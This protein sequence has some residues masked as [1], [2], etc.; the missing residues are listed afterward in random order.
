MFLRARRTDKS[1]PQFLTGLLVG[2]EGWWV[3]K[4]VTC[5]IVCT[6]KM[7]EL[8]L[9]LYFPSDTLVLAAIELEGEQWP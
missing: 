1:E 6:V 5:Q 9:I 4:C 8:T 3:Q 7:E 2:H